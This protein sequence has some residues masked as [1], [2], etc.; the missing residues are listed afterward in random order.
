M[1]QPEP[2]EPIE[3][4][5]TLLSPD[6][7]RGLVESFV[8]REG[9][10]Y[11]TREYSHE[12]KVAQVMAQLVRGDVLILFDPDTESATLQNRKV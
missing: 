3:V 5:H 8:L 12:E 9:T 2:A 7:L 1:E 11:G 4:P 10:D 6:A